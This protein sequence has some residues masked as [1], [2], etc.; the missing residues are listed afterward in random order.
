MLF[1][2]AMV[3]DTLSPWIIPVN[4][5]NTRIGMRHCGTKIP[6]GPDGITHWSIGFSNGK[7]YGF[8]PI[9]SLYD[10]DLSGRSTMPRRVIVQ[11][12]TSLTGVIKQGDQ[13]KLGKGVTM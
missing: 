5:K 1:A 2:L 3:S 12:I 10:V 4:E 9:N 7:Y 13:A 6:Y 11:E 8:Q